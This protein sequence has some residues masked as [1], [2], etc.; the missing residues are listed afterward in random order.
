MY[1]LNRLY[2]HSAWSLA[3]TSAAIVV[4]F[5]LDG[6]AFFEFVESAVWRRRVVEEDI[7]PIRRDKTKTT[8]RDDLLNNTLWH[9]LPSSL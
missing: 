8:I 2:S 6:L 1:A 4:E 7:A 9:L 3:A 5:I